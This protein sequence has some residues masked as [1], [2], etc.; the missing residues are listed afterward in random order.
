MALSTETGTTGQSPTPSG[1]EF[2]DVHGP[3]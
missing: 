2:F 3:A 1:A